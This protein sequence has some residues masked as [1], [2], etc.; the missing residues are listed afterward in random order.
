MDISVENKPI[1]IGM[2][3]F[4]HKPITNL[5]IVKVENNPGGKR[6][7][8][9]P[10]GNK[11]PSVT[12]MLGHKEKPWLNDWR[13]SLGV[14]KAAKE[15]KRA[16]ERGDAIHKLIEIYLNNKLDYN[17]TKVYDPEYI[18]GFN[19][20]KLRLNTIDNIRAQEIPLYSDTLKVAGRID[21][22][23]EY[24]G[25]L[26]VVD[27]KT[28]TN[29]KYEDMI[30]DYFLQTTAYAIMWHEITGEPIE[31]L[32]IIMSVEKGLV[33]LVFKDKIDKY[34]KPLLLRIN[35]YYKDTQ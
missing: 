9:T 21:C 28:S 1:N 20:V 22:I 16:S 19:Q 3:P 11:Y 17:I 29:V 13:N 5:P 10:E 24:E 32:V 25:V 34:V 6:Y 27:F 4:A 18:A 33:P 14:D 31:D 7:Y 35:D 26:S 15:T 30:Q 8:V 23:A 2:S 12:T